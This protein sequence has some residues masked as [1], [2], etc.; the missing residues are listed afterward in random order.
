M[1]IS[2]KR[3][4]RLAGRKALITDG[5][6]GLGREVSL[7]FA[8]EG[9][10][11]AIGYRSVD[12]DAA[13]T[14]GALARAAGARVALLAG[15]LGDE[16]VCCDIVDRA[17]AH[18]GGL[19]TLVVIGGRARGNLSTPRWLSQA[20]LTHLRDGSAVI[21]ASPLAVSALL[22]SVVL[23]R[24]RRRDIRMRGIAPSRAAGTS[25]EL[26]AAYI[27]LAASA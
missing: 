26:T 19:D 8:R 24:M 17:V 20:A 5:D 25:T 22:G 1:S 16:G 14:T 15:D 6:F 11:L 13:E 27:D 4:G 2:G 12:P 3:T 10:D 9:A 23:R 21:V 7:A 18:L